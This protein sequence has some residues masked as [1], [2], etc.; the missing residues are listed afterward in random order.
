MDKEAREML[1]TFD[2][3]DPK[4]LTIKEWEA[5]K[6]LIEKRLQEIQNKKGDKLTIDL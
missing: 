3:R 5:Y 1:D 4:T 6:E 2:R